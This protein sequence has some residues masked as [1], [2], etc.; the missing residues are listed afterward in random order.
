MTAA[1]VDLSLLTVALDQAGE[2]LGRVPEDRLDASTPC[3]SWT[4]G[5]LV[6]HLVNAPAQFATMLRGDQPD[7]V[8]APPH[9]GTDREQRFRA[10][11]E[12]LVAAWQTV[13]H[14]EQPATLDWQL[15]ELAVHTWDLATALGES[16]GELAPEVAERGLAF[17][18]SGLTDDNRGAAFG[19]EQPAPAGGDAYARIAA[20]AGRPARSPGTG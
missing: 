7:W 12:D 16:T 20:F 2:V 14:G 10:A 5:E 11:G 17:M 8:A 3:S 6:D 9:V 19:P 18:R 4:V 1:P 15:A 13:G